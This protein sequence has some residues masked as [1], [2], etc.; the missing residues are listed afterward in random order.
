MQKKDL[1][2]LPEEAVGWSPGQA[3]GATTDLHFVHLSA[4]K[5]TLVHNIVADRVGAQK[6]GA[7][8]NNL[9]TQHCNTTLAQGGTWQRQ[10]GNPGED[11]AGAQKTDKQQNL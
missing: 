4:C 2:K 8:H 5:T 6:T 1:E 3:A 7:R 11:R 9:W 10:Q